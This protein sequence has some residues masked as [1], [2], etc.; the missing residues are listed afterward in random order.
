M[1]RH[2]LRKQSKGENWLSMKADE[3]QENLNWLNKLVLN[4]LKAEP[5][6][7]QHIPYFKTYQPNSGTFPRGVTSNYLENPAEKQISI[8]QRTLE[9]KTTNTGHTSK[10]ENTEQKLLTELA[11][12]QLFSTEKS[13]KKSTELIDKISTLFGKYTFPQTLINHK[14]SKIKPSENTQNQQI[15]I[16]KKVHFKKKIANNTICKDC[17]KPKTGIEESCQIVKPT[18]NSFIVSKSI[19]KNDGDRVR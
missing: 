19:L 13:L 2:Y 8:N 15:V 1:H 5:L 14:V 18:V 3:K 11:L 4:G 16:Q 12:V 7:A 9:P 10:D 17:L 6:N